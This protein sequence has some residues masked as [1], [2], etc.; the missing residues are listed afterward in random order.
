MRRMM[1]LR[2]QFRADSKHHARHVAR[3]A[4]DN[5]IVYDLVI[6][7][8]G[9]FAVVR[10]MFCATAALVSALAQN[11]DMPPD[12][13]FQAVHLINLP[14][15]EAEKSLLAALTDLNT[16]IA[17]AGC[18]KCGYHLWK[19]YGTQA[20]GY[21]YLWMSMWPGRDVYIKV[22]ESADYQAAI[23]RHQGIEDVMKNQTYNRYVEVSK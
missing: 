2:S 20:G 6:M 22:H 5:P 23:N 15:A 10:L 4:N 3:R 17:K 1:E 7:L 19:V 13:P 12:Q 18:A 8:K 21:N 14:S 11:N 16:A 9:Q